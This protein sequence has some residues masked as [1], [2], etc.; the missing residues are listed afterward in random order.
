MMLGKT[1]GI[2]YKNVSV[3]LHCSAQRKADHGEKLVVG[4]WGERSP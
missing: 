3:R 1:G 2:G 4:C